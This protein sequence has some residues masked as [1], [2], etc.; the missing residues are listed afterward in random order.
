MKRTLALLLVLAIGSLGLQ[1]CGK[2]DLSK[3][4]DHLNTTAKALNAAAKTNRLFYENGTYG[5]TGSPEAIAFRQ[6]GA[7]AVH[8]ANDKLIVALNLAKALTPATFEQGK[9]GVLAALAEAKGGLQIGNPAFDLVL[10]SIITSITTIVA[11]IE[12]FQSYQL[13]HV[14]PEIQSWKIAEV[15]V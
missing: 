7:T 4:H 6:K 15:E 11:L 9:L 8:T 3:L 1:G 2:S 12:A 13:K 14:L 10:S 5:P